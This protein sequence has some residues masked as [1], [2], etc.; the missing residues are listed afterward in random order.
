MSKRDFLI[1][2]GVEE[3]P[4]KAVKAA[5]LQLTEKIEGWLKDNNI[6]YG[7]SRSYATPRRLALMIEGVA[8]KQED[9]E[10]EAKG[11]SKKIAVDDEGNWSKAAQGFARGQGV[12]PDDFYFKE[13]KG[14][15]YIYI[16]KQ[17][18]GVETKE[19]LSQLKELIT[20]MTFSKN[21]RWGDNELRFIRPVRWL[22]ALFGSD[23][24]P[25]EIT[26]I[27]S[28]ITSEGHRFL[29]NA[30]QINEPKEYAI[31]LL[32]EYVIADANE[33]KNAIKSQLRTLEE[34]K[35]WVIPMDS[36]LLEEVTQ[37]V[38]Y[39][40]AIFGSF[41]PEFLTLPKEVLITSMRE[42]QRY[43]PVQNEE[44]ELLPYFVTIRN[45][46]VDFS[47]MVVKGNEKVLRARLADARFFYEEDK[48]LD[49]SSAVSQLENIVFHEDLGSLGDKV[50]RIREISAQLAGWLKHDVSTAAAVDRS[51]EICKFDL[52]SQMVNEFPEL[53]GRMGEEYA[54]LAGEGDVVSKAIFE[55]YLPRYAGDQLPATEVGAIVSIAD[56]IDTIV[57]CFSL[58]LVPTG[59]Q[60]PYA[61]RR[62]ASGIVHILLQEKW[63][64]TLNQLFS[65]A[66]KTFKNRQ[67]MKRSPEEVEKELQSFFTLRL[68]NRMQE[69]GIR[70]DVIDAVL[71]DQS[72]ET[73]SFFDKANILMKQVDEESFKP[74]VEAFTRVSNLADKTDQHKNTIQASKFE[75]NVE[76]ALYESYKRVKEDVE[77]QTEEGKWE[78]AY[79]SLSQL[80]EPIEDFFDQV[81]VMVED[82]GL[83]YN[84]LALL[85]NIS[86]LIRGYAD[87]SQIVFSSK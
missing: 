28:G 63:A 64:I 8:E 73:N 67:L 40:T 41:D 55:H 51:A 19:L 32:K 14:V 72:V 48:K 36:E 61:L 42:H 1:E 59:S 44:G 81:M 5:S 35:K 58:G 79:L 71:Q 70:Y 17:I 10:E 20:G 22:V 78:G 74:L 75:S 80:K 57:G 43:F 52:I 34:E 56:K 4:A 85:Q 68:K 83:R 24:I 6:S 15:E 86:L 29:G 38:E 21:M 23:V 9:R 47:G 39:P 84:R 25:L 13:I 12:S 65:I 76:H 46:G 3:M 54:L 30:I 69:Q 66:L 53:Q 18:K 27:Q 26:G 16:T 45:G 7:V 33:R 60:D 31:E 87:F 82:D 77:K 62:Q 37:L 49:I 50:R 2:I 11:P